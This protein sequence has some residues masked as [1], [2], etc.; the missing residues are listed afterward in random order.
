MASGLGYGSPDEF[1]RQALEL[2]PDLVRRVLGEGS[3]KAAATDEARAVARDRKRRQRG[4]DLSVKPCS[5]CGATF[6]PKRST[7]RFCSTRCR[8]AA[9]R[10]TSD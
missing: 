7:A 4:T 1:M 5:H 9:H 10:A 8:V 3:P 6:T 2:D